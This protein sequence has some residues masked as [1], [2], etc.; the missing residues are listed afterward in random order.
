MRLTQEEKNVLV[1]L[2]SDYQEGGT[3][4]KIDGVD[5]TELIYKL[6]RMK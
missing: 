1:F 5:L 4:Y 6:K 3:R 2:L